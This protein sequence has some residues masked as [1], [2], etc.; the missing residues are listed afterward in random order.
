[1]FE[2]ESSPRSKVNKEPPKQ[3]YYSENRYT[4]NHSCC[5]ICDKTDH[6]TTT[7]PNNSQI[8][9]YFA[10]EEFVK[11]SPADRFT[12]LRKKRLSFQC[13]FPGADWNTGKHKEGKCQRD[14]ACQHQTHDKFTR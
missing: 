8:V 9:Q 1:M 12:I 3:S 2:K 6:V 13:L 4:S 11:M 5:S 10:C 7:G 14:F